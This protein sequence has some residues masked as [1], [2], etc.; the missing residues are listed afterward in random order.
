MNCFVAGCRSFGWNKSYSWEA[1]EWYY[2]AKRG[3]EQH[4]RKVWKPGEDFA[5]NFKYCGKS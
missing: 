4:A 3:G 2:Q 1:R 5:E